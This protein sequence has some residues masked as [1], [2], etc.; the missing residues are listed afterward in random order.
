MA[1]IE[2]ENCILYGSKNQET[3]EWNKKIID[4]MKM[5]KD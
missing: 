2:V 4:F 1:L 5:W 3:K